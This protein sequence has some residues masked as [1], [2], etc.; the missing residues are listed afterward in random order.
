MAYPVQINPLYVGELYSFSFCG[1][2]DAIIDLF[3]FPYL[4]NTPVVCLCI[5]WIVLMY[6]IEDSKGKSSG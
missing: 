3:I 4:C 6:I 1:L 2:L 5:F